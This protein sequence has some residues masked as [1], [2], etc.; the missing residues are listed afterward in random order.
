MGR[1]PRGD[2]KR[3]LNLFVP[4]EVSDFAGKDAS[5]IFE[6]AVRVKMGQA[7]SLEDVK[8]KV[9]GNL[10]NLQTYLL[11]ANKK[12]LTEQEHDSVLQALAKIRQLVEGLEGHAISRK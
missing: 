4:K 2:E 8:M 6:Q 3:K 12:V 5:A 1:L 9:T 10:N 11:P 7:Y